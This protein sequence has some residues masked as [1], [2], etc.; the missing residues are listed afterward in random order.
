MSYQCPTCHKTLKHKKSL[1]DHIAK[2]HEGQEPPPADDDDT[3][4]LV[5]TP[6]DDAG[7]N[8]HCVDCG[9]GVSKGQGEC[10]KCGAELSWGDLDDNG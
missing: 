7:Q 5:I 10:P 8:Y 9:T 3:G 1:A 2:Y 6:P 4:G